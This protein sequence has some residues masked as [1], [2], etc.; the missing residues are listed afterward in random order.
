MTK[1]LKWIVQNKLH[2]TKS[3]IE[4]KFFEKELSKYYNQLQSI[5]DE[6]YCNNI[7]RSIL[8]NNSMSKSDYNSKCTMIMCSE[9]KQGTKCGLC[10]L[11]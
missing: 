8:L 5:H 9:I 4:K 3:L 2:Q 11:M 10:S 6:M 7:Q 1:L